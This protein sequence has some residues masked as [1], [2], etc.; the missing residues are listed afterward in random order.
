MHIFEFT[1]DLGSARTLHQGG[2]AAAEQARA[3][4]NSR[5]LTGR[6]RS[7]GGGPQSEE[8][9]SAFLRGN[10][11]LRSAADALAVIRA[12]ERKYGAV[13]EYRFQK[14]FELPTHYQ[15]IIS[16]AFRDPKAYERIPV[17]TE[18]FSVT[19]PG[20]THDRPGGVGLDE[21]EPV[22]QS[23]DY[24]ESSLPSFGNIMDD[25]DNG[26]EGEGEEVT[27]TISRADLNWYTPA[28]FP[29]SLPASE[30]LSR[31]FIRWGGFHELQPIS[32]ET[33]ISKAD[34]FRPSTIDSPCMRL[35]LRRHSETLRIPNPYEA[36]STTASDSSQPALN[37]EPLPGHESAPTDTPM[38]SV[39]QAT[40]G[41][42]FMVTQTSAPANVNSQKTES[43]PAT[44]PEIEHTSQPTTLR[45]T[46]TSIPATVAEVEAIAASMEN[47][48]SRPKQTTSPKQKK[49]Q[50]QA[51]AEGQK[52]KQTSLREL[53]NQA[54]QARQRESAKRAEKQQELEPPTVKQ[55]L[56]NFFSNIF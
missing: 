35:A 12:V 21:L 42:P 56:S 13:R 20:T 53:R 52:D 55:K 25:I 9:D 38:P 39:I 5:R 7:R 3:S 31:C 16:V 40:S 44:V 26:A 6:T 23:A 41:Q 29:G 18:T 46:S 36:L 34:I 4:R 43:A 47:S 22:L 8:P 48:P 45:D 17:E 32:A 33:P 11:F 15:H 51:P 10:K 14:D 2:A 54:L 50:R 30:S 19:L 49:P 27:F 28:T 37:W 24:V 1:H